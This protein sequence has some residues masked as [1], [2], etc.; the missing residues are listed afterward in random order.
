MVVVGWLVGLCARASL[1]L[2]PPPSGRRRML[3]NPVNHHP[4]LQSPAALRG[5]AQPHVSPMAPPC[6]HRTLHIIPDCCSYHCAPTN[7]VQPLTAT[8][9]MRHG[10][11]SLGDSASRAMNGLRLNTGVWLWFERLK[12]R[13]LNVARAPNGEGRGGMQLMG[14]V[15]VVLFV[16]AL[17]A[18]CGWMC[19]R[20]C[21]LCAS[22]VCVC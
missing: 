19:A 12:V 18:W 13:G 17:H 3:V 1:L 15:W 5:T 6:H 7:T 14:L 16:C 21:I 4:S 8:L 11:T 9:S 22:L 10:H 2:V 20:V